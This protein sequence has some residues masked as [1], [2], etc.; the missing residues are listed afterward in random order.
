M[1]WKFVWY[2][3]IKMSNLQFN[4]VTKTKDALFSVYMSQFLKK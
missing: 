1:F 2:V 4:F 3:G